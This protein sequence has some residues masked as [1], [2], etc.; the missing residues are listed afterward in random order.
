LGSDDMGQGLLTAIRK[1]YSQ[2][3]GARYFS[4]RVRFN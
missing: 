1:F 3:G 2:R 4:A